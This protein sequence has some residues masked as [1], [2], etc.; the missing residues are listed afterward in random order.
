M[1]A[2][3]N[4]NQENARHDRNQEA[5]ESVQWISPSAKAAAGVVIAIRGGVL[6]NAR[7]QRES[8]ACRNES[9]IPRPQQSVGIAL[10]LID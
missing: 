2:T 10:I 1:F 6:A 7:T 4:C 3:R 9:A 5:I 8:L